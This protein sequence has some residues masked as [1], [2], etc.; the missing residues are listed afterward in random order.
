MRG[1]KAHMCHT[2]ST[3]WLAFVIGP[4]SLGAQTAP[5]P[6]IDAAT[7]TRVIEG[8]A[9]QLDTFYVFP[10]V[11]KRV[12]DSLRARLARGAYDGYGNGVT[13]AKRLGDDL[14]EVGRDKHLRLE[15]SA[16]PFVGPTRP[17]ADEATRERQW[18]D[19]L[20]CGF[21]KAEQLT[22]NI[23]YL[24]FDMFAPPELCASTAA[25]AMNFLAASSALILDLRDNG[26][27]D[28]RMVAYISSYL[29]AHRT[30]L[31]DLW[32]RYTGATDEFWTSDGVAGRR[33]GGDKPVYVLTS[34]RTFSGAEEFAYNLKSL[35]RATIVGEIT[36]GGAH[37]V[38]GRPLDPHFMIGVPMA[39]AI[40]PIT[41]TNW[42]GVGVE[43]DVKTPAG[44]AL[45]AAQKILREPPPR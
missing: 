18:M 7:R 21:V 6:R 43:P 2:M 22:G 5:V 30:H 4:S 29:F 37:P 41:H 14:R 10:A 15:Y 11:A 23:G 27:G 12:G 8:A 32:T 20:N 28:P 26:G 1:S 44:G 3:L 39:R 38:M 16:R 36:A 17:S 25:A 31:N 35:R 45:A 24:K 13:F 19:S 34:S 40:N 33:Y 42:E 9:A